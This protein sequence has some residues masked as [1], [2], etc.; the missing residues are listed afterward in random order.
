MISLLYEKIVLYGGKRSLDS[1]RHIY[2]HYYETL[3]KFGFPVVWVDDTP[4]ARAEITG[5][6][7]V[8]AMD[9]WGEHIGHAV[10]GAD[11]I[12]HNFDG[13]HPLCQTLRPENLV[14]LQVYTDSAEGEYWG[15][16]RRWQP[17]GH[18]LFQPWGTDL[19][20]EEFLEPVFN[21][22]SREAPFVGAIWD[23]SGL[24][25]VEAINELRI[26]LRNHQLAFK[27][28]THISDEENVLAVRAG[29]IAP[30]LAGGWQVKHNYLPCRVFKNVSYGQ[31]ALTNVP[32]FKELFKGFT[33][34][35]S[36][37]S[38]LVEEALGLRRADYIE[39]THQQQLVVAN[40]SYREALEHWGLA[41]A[42]VKQ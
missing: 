27:H 41:L 10:P 20:A 11:Y 33:L 24:G 32:K 29:R 17:E 23:D 9:I 26:A 8:F 25:N 7:L 2:R 35:G 21:P 28:F 13:E 4:Q 31:L 14:R 42:Q 1:T 5:K 16:V 19:L 15:P 34:T 6:S 39:M 30:A 40:Y 3:R 36:S 18:V 37:I 22:M 12:L 38:E